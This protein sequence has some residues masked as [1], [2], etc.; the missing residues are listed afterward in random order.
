MHDVSD[1]LISLIS[2]SQ[3][4]GHAEC[5][6]S[7]VAI[8]LRPSDVSQMCVC[9]ALLSIYIQLDACMARRD[10]QCQVARRQGT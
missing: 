8:H 2:R 4:P 10:P 6:C 3:H 9:V 7:E 1:A 5:N